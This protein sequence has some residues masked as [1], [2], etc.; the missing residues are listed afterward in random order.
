MCFEGGCFIVTPESFRYGRVERWKLGG[1]FILMPKPHDH[2]V[3]SEDLGLNL[4]DVTRR[5]EGICEQKARGDTCKLWRLRLVAYARVFSHPIRQDG[6]HCAEEVQ[7][8][9]TYRFLV[10]VVLGGRVD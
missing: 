6:F 1:A 5:K 9:G 4:Y 8:F 7:V 3:S 10:W 2:P